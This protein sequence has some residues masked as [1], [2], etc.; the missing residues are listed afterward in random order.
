MG[1]GMPCQPKV[2]YTPAHYEHPFARFLSAFCPRISGRPDRTWLDEPFQRQRFDR[3]ESRQ[4]RRRGPSRTAP[5]WRMAWP[6]TCTTTA[7]S[8]NHMFR[9][10]ELKVD[11]MAKR[12]FK[13]RRL[14]PDRI[15]GHRVPQEGIRDPGEQHLRRD[16]VKTG[17]L[18]H[19][20][21]VTEALPKDDEWFT[22]HIIVKGNNITVKVNDKQ[23]VD[24]TQP[25][26][27]NGGT[28]GT[29]ARD[30]SA[31]DD[32]AAGP[33]PEQHGVLQ[34]YP[35]QTARLTADGSGGAGA[36]RP[37]P[38]STY[39]PLR[40]AGS[41]CTARTPRAHPRGRAPTATS[42]RGRCA[43]ASAAPFLSTNP[44]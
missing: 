16:P 33:R 11:V 32:R 37:S 21:D 9:N 5:S 27:W 29:R 12:E 43:P 38:F 23:V 13:R 31:R 15:P 40:R 44:G 42:C 22:E 26:D 25:A 4:R 3:L 8:S 28:R 20:Q 30:Q 6:D 17:S 1:V 34:E 7:S 24:W 41:P 10:F 35:D 18:Y 19:V 14:C 39:L 36:L 2:C